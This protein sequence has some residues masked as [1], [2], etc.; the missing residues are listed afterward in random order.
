MTREGDHLFAQLGG[1]PRFEIF[2]RSP[3]E[4][5]WKVVD[6]QVTFIK[7][8]TGRVSK[9]EHHQGG[10]SL[11]APRLEEPAAITL[12]PQALDAFVGKYDYGQGKV[13]LTVTRDGNQMFAQLTGQPRFE[14]FPKSPTQFFWKVV[15]ARITFVKDASGKVTKGIHEQDGRTMDVPRIE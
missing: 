2:P 1:Q 10:A 12:E 6:A 15:N 9:A 4:F 8:S 14:I 7:D 11:D 5:F 13:I 3:T